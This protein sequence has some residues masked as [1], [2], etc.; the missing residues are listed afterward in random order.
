MEAGEGCDDEATRDVEDTPK[1]VREVG[2]GEHSD[3]DTEQLSQRVRVEQE[4][5]VRPA[6][7]VRARDAGVVKTAGYKL[8]PV[9]N[10]LR[11]VLPDQDS[12]HEL[13][14]HYGGPVQGQHDGGEQGQVGH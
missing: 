1:A 14:L 2:H 3:P 4:G 10:A 6:Q 8:A 9:N 5:G 12:E 13:S 7:T 11:V